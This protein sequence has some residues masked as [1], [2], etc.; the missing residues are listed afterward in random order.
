M[1]KKLIKLTVLC[2]VFTLGL[3]SSC[4]SDFEQTNT[5]P[6]RLQ[7]IS[8]ATLL[9]PMIYEVASQ[10]MYRS[11]NQNSHLMQGVLNFP[12]TATATSI[13]HY[14]LSDNVGS[15]PWNLY[16][17][18]LKNA[19]LMQEAS[20][21]YQDPNYQ[22]IALT[23]QVWM[24]ANLVDLFGDIPYFDAS[25]ADQN[26]LYPAFDDQQE[27]YLDL[28]AS[29]DK[30]NTLYDHT[31]ANVYYPDILYNNDSKKWQ[32][33]T[34]SLH[35][36]LLLRSSNKLKD[37][38]FQKMITILQDPLSYPIIESKE[39]EATLQ[40]TGIS[41]NVSPWSRLQDFTL[42][43]KMGAFF[44]DNLNDLDDPRRLVFA[45][46]ASRIVDGKKQNIGY[47]GIPSAYQG[48]D[49]Q[50]DYEASTLNNSMA[51]V[52]TKA[53]LL[54]YSEVVFIKAELA[55]KGFL[56]DAE[57]LYKQA[58]AAAMQ[59]HDIEIPI[60]YFENPKATYNATLEQLILQKYYALYMNDY[61]QWFEY[62]RTGYPILPKTIAMQ[63]NQELPN[64]FP[65]PLDIR[66]KNK[67]NYEKVIQKI[68]S[69]N[70]NIKS[71]WQ[72]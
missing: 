13:Q 1:E 52:K 16:Y 32:K 69:D 12:A 57:G 4:T 72:N 55:L 67:S 43:K 30:A 23:M 68:G 15:A 62:K 65:Y 70:I 53:P 59:Y 7:N 2:V 10:N 58:V 54:T 39:E 42:S 47:K 51:D 6:N 3:F 46:T 44:I 25:K 50:F 14:N 5:D 56:P 33:F 63:N 40:I 34:N 35:L 20:I 22:A 27:V 29:L 9:N 36:R 24:A 48:P 18:F 28:L 8:P 41:P 21:N 11:W 60:D 45:T 64:R 37:Q 61:Q 49:S 38:A 71:W 26:I 31:R 17:R 66:T 19:R